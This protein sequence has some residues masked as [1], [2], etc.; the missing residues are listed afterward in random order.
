VTLPVLPT[1]AED[2]TWRRV[3][4]APLR[5]QLR[6]FAARGLPRTGVLI[7]QNACENSCFF[8]ANAGVTRPPESAVTRLEHIERWLEE[9]RGVTVDRLCVGGTEPALHP[10]FEA[11]LRGLSSAKL[12]PV[13]VM[14]SG[15]R[16]AEPGV[17][18]RWAELGVRAVAVPLYA[19]T[20]RLH[21]EVVGHRGAF[22]LTLAGLDNARA[23]GMDVLVHT[24]ALR[25]TACE[26]AALGALVRTRYASRLA[27]GAPRPKPGVWH[28]EA[29]A[30]TASELEQ[31]P[32]ELD[33]S[34]VGYP[35]CV[36]RGNTRGAAA[37][38]ELYFQGS[39]REYA[40]E[41]ARCLDRPS[42]PGV[43]SAELMRGFV[44][45]PRLAPAP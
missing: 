15:L 5:E 14:T 24:L 40:S 12:G 41:C 36:G 17:A 13:E 32:P 31:Q 43:L 7:L 45:L 35:H 29:E 9:A 42:C 19:A 33:V 25:R 8:C 6:E 30:L 37:V 34:L 39:R 38:I 10:A 3:L 44:T 26:L 1:P 16:L 2:E 27:L 20:A 28:W 11:A 21:D 23:A 4:V 22:E 18:E